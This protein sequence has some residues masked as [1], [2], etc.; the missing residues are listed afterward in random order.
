[1]DDARFEDAAERPLRLKAETPEDLAVLSALL[2]DAVGKVKSARNLAAKAVDVQS[3]AVHGRVG[4]CRL[5]LG[6]DPLI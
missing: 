4:Q 6:S 1:M 5:Q 3:D 2:Q